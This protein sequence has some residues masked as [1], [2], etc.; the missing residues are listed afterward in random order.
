[1][2]SMLVMLSTSMKGA[3]APGGWSL[4][5]ENVV[6]IG[7]S[8]NSLLFLL[9][10]RTPAVKTEFIWF[11][12]VILAESWCLLIQLVILEN[13]LSRCVFPCKGHSGAHLMSFRLGNISDIVFV[14]PYRKNRLT[15]ERALSCDISSLVT[16]GFEMI[17]FI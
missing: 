16:Y 10:P 15:Y 11:I 6:G 8:P 5:I 2:A 9:A 1:M 14:A 12:E 7:L 4:K 3:F 17:F 13:L